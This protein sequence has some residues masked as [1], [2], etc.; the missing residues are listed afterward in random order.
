MTPRRLEES[1]RRGVFLLADKRYRRYYV[2]MMTRE[3]TMTKG[4]TK[5][6]AT[7]P[8]DV[9]TPATEMLRA[10]WSGADADEVAGL[11]REAAHEAVFALGYES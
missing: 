9:R 4:E 8:G 1:Y 3:A 7:Y 2:P 6:T 11:A 10:L 5:R